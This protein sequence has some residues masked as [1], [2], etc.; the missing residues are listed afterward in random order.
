MYGEYCS[1]HLRDQIVKERRVRTFT[2]KRFES[3]K[4]PNRIQARVPVMAAKNDA[5]ALALTEK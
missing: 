1:V 3:R 5:R 4:N 2:D